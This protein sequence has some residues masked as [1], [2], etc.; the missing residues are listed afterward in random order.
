M[1]RRHQLITSVVMIVQDLRHCSS[2]GFFHGSY[3]PTI[4][5]I[6]RYPIVP[7][8][9]A[10]GCLSAGPAFS[11]LKEAAGQHKATASGLPDPLEGRL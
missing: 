11:P 8:A 9:K 3:K 2:S 5:M 7:I 6:S 4:V 10:K 1:Y